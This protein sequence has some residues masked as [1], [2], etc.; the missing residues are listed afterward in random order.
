MNI[1]G[2]WV[3][4]FLARLFATVAIW[5]R[6]QTS[7]KIQKNGDISKEMANTPARTQKIYKKEYRKKQFFVSGSGFNQVI[8]SVSRSGFG[9]WIRIQEGKNR[10]K[11]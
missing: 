5:V 11:N 6:I 9:I 1:E 4:K 8:G 3:A 2:R 7:L 10:K